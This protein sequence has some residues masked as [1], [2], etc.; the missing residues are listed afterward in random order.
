MPRLPLLIRRPRNDLLTAPIS[1]FESETQAVIVRTSPYS[2][3][4]ILHALVATVAIAILFMS[5]VRLDR[6]VTS[7]GRLVPTR[8]TLYV[9]PFD[10]SVVRQ[11]KVHPGDVVK[12]GQ[13]LA[14]LD[15]TFAEADVKQQRDHAAILSAM[16]ARLTAE[17]EGRPYEA[18]SSAAEQLQ[19]SIWHQRQS[20]L[21]QTMADFDARI[22]SDEA[23]IAKAQQDV[24]AYTQRLSYASQVAEMEETLLKNG[25]AS[26]LKV[27]EA[28]DAK[29]EASRQLSEARNTLIG[30]QHDLDA[31]KAQR[32]VAIGKWHDDIGTQLSTSRD[33]L[34][35]TQQVLAKANRVNDLSSLV[36][37]EDAIVLEIGE[38]S[39]GSIVDSTGMSR[40]LF[41][42]VPIGGPMEAEIDI[43]GQEIGFVRKGDLATIKF[44]AYSYL[45]HGTATGK[46]TSISEGTFTQSSEGVPRAPYF[47][48]RMTIDTVHLHNVPDGFRLIPGMT[49]QADDLVGHRTILSY[50]VSGFLRTGNEAMREP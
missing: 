29:T 1:A 23:T 32:A 22:H 3:H 2:E 36:A 15:P 27:L 24:Q 28:S 39:R 11:I 6:V 9:Q 26:K 40:P 46:I 21:Q 17:L 20:E 7:P 43:S 50:L 47:K 4:A 45:R 18:G 31:L 12:A 8:G 38:A 41:T 13:V 48:A 42:L 44:D 25:N 35:Q 37:P 30:T 14:E 34:Q 19:L 5:V 16:V 10:R 33:D 49:I